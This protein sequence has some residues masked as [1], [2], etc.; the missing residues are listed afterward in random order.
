[1]QRSALGALGDPHAGRWTGGAGGA[2]VALFAPKAAHAGCVQSGESTLQ[3]RLSPNLRIEQLPSKRRILDVSGTAQTRHELKMGVINSI[4]RFVSAS[5]VGL[6]EFFV[7]CLQGANEPK[8]NGFIKKVS[9]FVVLQSVS[10]IVFIWAAVHLHKS[11]Q[12]NNE[13]VHNQRTA[14]LR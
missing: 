8:K 1:M 3:L 6:G 4:K 7:V 2:R 5:R 12:I 14:I 11:K 9:S 13:Y 10:S